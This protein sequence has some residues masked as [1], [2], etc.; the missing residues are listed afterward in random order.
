MGILP[1]TPNFQ[2]CIKKTNKIP[3]YARDYRNEWLFIR[4]INKT[5]FDLVEKYE[6]NNNQ[7]FVSS[8]SNSV[9]YF[10][11]NFLKYQERG[12]IK[13]T[14]FLVFKK[15]D[16]YNIENLF[17]NMQYDFEE[18]NKVTNL[19][20][21][22]D[23]YDLFCKFYEKINIRKYDDIDDVYVRPIEYYSDP[24]TKE[25]DFDSDVIDSDDS[26]DSESESESDLIS[27]RD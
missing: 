20:G 19:L 7:L 16:V 9:K 17:D 8:C 12:Y 5:C 18:K 21:F 4:G 26:D 24:R 3:E 10:I 1:R 23:F 14:S 13:D 22:R 6:N 25:I 15:C 2:N 11:K 27:F